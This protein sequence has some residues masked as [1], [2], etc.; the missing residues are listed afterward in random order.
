[1]NRT[2]PS[3][4]WKSAGGILLALL[5]AGGLAFTA[6]SVRKSWRLG[7]WSD[8]SRQCEVCQYAKARVNPSMAHLL[9]Q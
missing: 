3:P 6:H 2:G 1:M 5:L 9:A 8:A 4:F 7:D